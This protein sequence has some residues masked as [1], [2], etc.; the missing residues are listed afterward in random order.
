MPP[1]LTLPWPIPSPRPRSAPGGARAAAPWP[2]EEGELRWL[3][4]VHGWEPCEREWLLFLSLLAPSEQLAVAAE[5]GPKHRQR[6][7]AVSLLIQRHCVSK[8]RAVPLDDVRIAR[9]ERGK[10]FDTTPRAL[11]PQAAAAPPPINVSFSVSKAGSLLALASD[12]ALLIGTHLCPA[13]V[14]Y[15]SCFESL[16]LD[17]EATMT[18]SEWK[19]FAACA[20]DEGRVAAFAKAWA[21]KQAFVKARGDGLRY[22]LAECEVV[23]A[24]PPTPWTPADEVHVINIGGETPQPTAAS[25][26]AHTAGASDASP[27][28]STLRYAWVQRAT[29]AVAGAALPL[30]SCSLLGLECGGVIAVARGPVGE[31]VQSDDASFRRRLQR[32]LLP[33]GE[34]R[35]R[36]A[37]PPPAFCVTT[38]RQLLD[39]LTRAAG[40]SLRDEFMASA[41]AGGDSGAGV[42]GAGVPPRPSFVDVRIPPRSNLDTS[43]T[44]AVVVV[45]AVPPLAAQPARPPALAASNSTGSCKIHPRPPET[46]TTATKPRRPL[47]ALTPR[48]GGG[49]GSGLSPRWIHPRNTGE[50]RNP[51]EWPSWGEKRSLA[52][53]ECALQ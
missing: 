1:A 21:A 39:E 7:R 50:E 44:S 27:A 26:A 6:V 14:E 11:S 28:R 42:G 38:P 4:D 12:P 49:G 20:T 8:L 35:A 13:L 45:P 10:P 3:V 37:S 31:E 22:P 40:G 23:L 16:R 5:D 32:P 41:G 36:L 52:E 19:G 29:Y 48:G 25:A 18:S 51:N 30:W 9:T 33:H 34:V 2:R 24:G 15:R 17:F 46:S 47:S 53:G 43:S